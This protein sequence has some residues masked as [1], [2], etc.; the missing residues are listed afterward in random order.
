VLDEQRYPVG[1]ITAALLARRTAQAGP[2]QG[3]VGTP[4]T[5]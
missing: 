4:Q 1:V 2:R 3:P 5:V